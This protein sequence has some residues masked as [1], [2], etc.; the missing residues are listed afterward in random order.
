MAQSKTEGKMILAIIRGEDSADAVS[1]LNH[2][3]FYVTVLSTVGGFL[4]QK[5]ATLLI[6]TQVNLVDKA[7]DVLKKTAGRRMEPTCQPS[8]MHGEYSLGPASMGMPAVMVEQEVG[9]VTAF[10]LNVGDTVKH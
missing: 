2:N 7:L 1:A 4:R 8:S 3:G 5:S 6:C 10:V 9:G